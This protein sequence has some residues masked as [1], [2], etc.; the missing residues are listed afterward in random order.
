MKFTDFG[1][2]K[3]I[4]D[5]LE[6]IEF[7]CPTSIQQKVIPL[8][9]KYQNVIALAHT[10]T[11]KTHSFLL[12][13][14]N[15]LDLI[16]S[17][18]KSYVQAV[19]V[20]PTR[21]LAKQI[22]E[23]VRI[24][25][26]NNPD[27]S[28]AMFIGGEDINKSIEQLEKIQPQI[29]VGT[30][31]RLKELYDQNKL[32]L[33]TAKYVVIDECDMIFDLGFI[34]DVDY[35]MSKINNNPTIGIFSATI[36]EP[37]KIFA[38]KYVQNASFIDDSNNK[39]SSNNVKHILIDTKNRETEESL[40][41]IINSINPFLCLIFVNQKEEVKNIV[42]I[43]RKNN[44]TRVGEIHGDLQPRTR[45]TM[46]KK[47][48]NHEYN[49][50][51]ATDVASRGVDIEGVSHVIS[52]DLP[53]DLS[54]YVHRSGRTGR[55]KL[56][57][58]SYVIFNAKNKDKID[59]LTKKGIEFEIQK[60]VDNQLIDI[61]VKKQTKKTSYK[62]LDPES[63]KIISKYQ[64]KKVKPGYRKKRKQELEKVKSKIRRKHIKESIEK[65]KKEKYKK[66]RQELFD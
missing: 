50:V 31:T 19:I 23:N 11:G 53:K 47:I 8:F 12:P 17:R 40:T 54:Y 65:I 39:P 6:Q 62:E 13:I 15:N 56:T 35:L 49:Y 16:V 9:K 5:T 4:N 42:N 10:G 36:S 30:P 21:E 55:N 3:Y 45:M 61:T 57:G 41:K 46:L 2:K 26:K 27:L 66:R 25:S 18:E 38:K 37:L 28:C 52:I 1:F 24:F 64:N 51:I 29:V 33:T 7:I 34:E 43:L 20:T 22:Y 32:R 14:L 60:L 44:I 63:K 59:E 48:K 58:I